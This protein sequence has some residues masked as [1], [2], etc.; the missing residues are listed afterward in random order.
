MNLFKIIL[1]FIPFTSGLQIK[2]ILKIEEFF[3]DCSSSP[4]VTGIAKTD[5]ECNVDN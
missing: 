2:N 5:K 1:A 4:I 3:S